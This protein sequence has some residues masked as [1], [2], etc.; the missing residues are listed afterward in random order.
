MAPHS[1]QEFY[2]ANERAI[3]WLREIHPDTPEEEIVH[4]FRQSID[5]TESVREGRVIDTATFPLGGD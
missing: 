3:T 5:L 4:A 2:K 1:D